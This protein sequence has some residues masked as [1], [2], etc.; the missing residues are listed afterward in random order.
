MVGLRL[1]VTA[2]LTTCSD[3]G[4]VA[5]IMSPYS[6]KKDYVLNLNSVFAFR[7]SVIAFV[8]CWRNNFLCCIYNMDPG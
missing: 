2:V 5:L 7:V 8:C 3:W 1:H 4:H 6:T